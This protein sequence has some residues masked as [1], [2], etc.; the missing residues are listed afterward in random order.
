[1]LQISERILLTIWVGGMW[2]IG[3]IVAPTLFSML[4]D[5]SLAGSIA[6]RL[7]TIVSYV[8]L[9]S[10]V[11]LLAGLLFSLGMQ[12]FQAWRSWVLVGML[13]FIV[14]GQFVL[15]PKMEALK[16]AG[17]EG[18]A[19]AQFAMLH[20]IASILFLVNSLAGLVLVIFG[21]RA[22]HLEPPLGG[23]LSIP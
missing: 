14:V 22:Q 12:A 8:G 1:M 2:A 15:Q 10:G 11:I 16:I 4:E 20:G 5:R 23:S 19:V 7:F 6:G 9:I 17:V 3:Y 21:V 13:C 18:E